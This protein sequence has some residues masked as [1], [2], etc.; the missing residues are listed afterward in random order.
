MTAPDLS[1]LL[2]SHGHADYV[3]KCLATL[4]DG[5]RGLRYEI[6]LIDNLNEPG[7]AD[8]IGGPQAHLTIVANTAPMG[9]GAN[10][11]KAAGLAAGRVL[12]VLNPDTAHVAGQVA[13]A[14]AFLEAD[15]RR[16]VVAARL[17]NTD[18]SDQRNFR[19]FPSL[20][21]TALRA[22]GANG[23]RHQPRFFRRA[24]LADLQVSGPAQVDWV[25]GSFMLMRRSTFE[26]LGGFDE[27]FFMYY[28]DVDLCLRLRRA[29]LST[30]LFPDLVFEHD[31]RRDSSRKVL[32]PHQRH[33]IR[34]LLR[35]VRKSGALISPPD[36]PD[37]PEFD[38]PGAPMLD[39]SAPPQA[40]RNPG[41]AAQVGFAGAIVLASLAA[42]LAALGV[43][44]LFA[45]D[46]PAMRDAL[47]IGLLFSGMTLVSQI[48]LQEL[49]ARGLGD[50]A[51]RV[52][53]VVESSLMASF[54]LAVVL[55]VHG[56]WNAPPFLGFVALYLPLAT[57]AHA[58]VVRSYSRLLQSTGARIGVVIDRAVPRPGLSVPKLPIGLQTVV[59]EF[60]ISEDTLEDAAEHLA[61][62]IRAQQIDHIYLVAPDGS[63][64]E[65]LGFLRR[66][67]MFDVPIW[68]A[69]AGA[70][71]DFEVL[72]L[73]SVLRSRA[74]V[75]LKRGLDLAI[76]VGALALLAIPFAIIALIIFIEDPGPV[77]FSQPRLGRNQVPFRM[78]K[79]R[80]M[81]TKQ[82]DEMGDKLT[83]RD[84]S[85]ITR[86]GAILRRTSADELPQIFNVLRG[87]MSIVGP[88]PLPVGFHF[89]GQPF[90]RIIPN[91]ELRTRVKPG[92]TGLS[93]LKGLRGT[94]DTFE[95]A[96]RMM[97]ERTIYDNLYIDRW[98]IWLD[99]R[100]I[101]M[102]LVSGA[103]MS[104]AY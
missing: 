17:V 91:W 14:V 104:R 36:A 34:S 64:G 93:Q 59:R 33:H 26:Q 35:Y 24:M 19:G 92:I 102:T 29:G 43:V 65:V 44:A 77:F 45:T 27:G 97:L 16:G 41:V 49:H 10:V 9:F 100:I 72:R 85:R 6:I 46:P 67:S 25:Y 87:E 83:T 79:F 76:S 66:L 81:Y 86:V 12:L 88:R 94:P 31:H 70:N 48:M 68:H 58:L 3:R 7:F 84:D 89:H 63:E 37:E 55:L 11:N 74:R 15:A 2:V 80:S 90:D 40:P 50:T 13:E 30:W 73:R 4:P 61:E 54:P 8:R 22:L 57:V 39:L 38:Q 28:E 60:D 78:L 21:V 82:S 47:L 56:P 69:R 101:V 53:G 99:I 75:A 62:A 51:R 20:A 71:V 42:G 52:V 1:V 96:E 95:E 103:F 98:S 32:N 5:L 18:G 23:W